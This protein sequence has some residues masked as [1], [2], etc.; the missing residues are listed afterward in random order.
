MGDGGYSFDPLRYCGQDELLKAAGSLLPERSR[1]D[2]DGASGL[3]AKGR[4][5]GALSARQQQATDLASKLVGLALTSPR[6]LTPVVAS[7]S[8]PR[9]GPPVTH[10]PVPARGLTLRPA[11][12]RFASFEGSPGEGRASPPIPPPPSP[13]S[14]ASPRRGGPG[15]QQRQQQGGPDRAA[16]QHGDPRATLSPRYEPQ[17]FHMPRTPRQAR[18]L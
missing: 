6:L 14:P 7:L 9:M 16:L 18:I 3:L 15:W 17:P 4:A 13:F 1:R 12:G 8:P 2:G 10:S 5:E 11:G